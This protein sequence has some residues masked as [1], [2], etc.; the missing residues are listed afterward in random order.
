M[1][2]RFPWVEKIQTKL[3]NEKSYNMYDQWTQMILKWWMTKL[4]FS[5]LPLRKSAAG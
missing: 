3:D 1:K 4:L 2:E 5:F